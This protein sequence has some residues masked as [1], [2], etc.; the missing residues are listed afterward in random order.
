MKKEILLLLLMC[1]MTMTFAQ[2]QDYKRLLNT[3]YLHR[4]TNFKDIIG[5]QIETESV[6]YPCKL[7]P[8]VGEIKIGK[9]PNVVTLN[10]T[11]P[12]ARS[13]KVQ[14]TVQEFMKSTFADPKLYKMV[15]DAEDEN[16]V[17]TNVY[18]LSA[19]KSLLIFQTVYYKT[20]EDI[21]KNQFVITM[22]GK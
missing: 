22:Y 21:S 18:A 6:F 7:K 4:E 12:L 2:Q 16:Y 14:I 11:I 13:K 8:D 19:P 17:T 9:Y 10:W 15:S 20:T 5:E 1:S 3:F